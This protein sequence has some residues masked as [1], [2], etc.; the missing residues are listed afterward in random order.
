MA[1]VGNAV[2]QMGA[3]QIAEY[4]TKGS[5]TLAGEVLS[6]GDIKVPSM[7]FASPLSPKAGNIA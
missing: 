7:L 4:E 5:I 6:A 3:E 1:A 2:Q